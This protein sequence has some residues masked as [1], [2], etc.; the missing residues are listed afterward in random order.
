MMRSALALSSCASG[1][2]RHDHTWRRTRGGGHPASPTRR[3]RSPRWRP[4]CPCSTRPARLARAPRAASTPP[5]PP[6]PGQRAAGA[7]N[8]A[9]PAMAHSQHVLTAQ[10]T[11]LEHLG[12]GQ[13]RRAVG[14]DGA[15]LPRVQGRVQQQ[16]KRRVRALQ[17]AHTQRRTG[18]ERRIILHV[19]TR[20]GC[21][22]GTPT[23]RTAAPPKP[24]P[25]VSC[26]KPCPHHLRAWH[27]VHGRA[28]SPSPSPRPSRKSRTTDRREGTL[29]G[30]WC[31]PR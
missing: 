27:T 16:R 3:K 9:L 24:S 12:R 6:S 7:H 14:G 29:T 28:H 17:C 1:G 23:A 25:L 15:A 11:Y 5:R 31:W 18:G 30:S 19:L 21:S 20:P 2:H 26:V 10:R 13:R 8:Q 22:D 4:F